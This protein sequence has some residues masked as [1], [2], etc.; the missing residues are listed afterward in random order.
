[1]FLSAKRYS[2]LRLIAMLIAVVMVFSATV[3]T[4]VP[5]TFVSAKSEEQELKDEIARL[6]KEQKELKK[7]RDQIND[8]LS[9]EK[10]KQESYQKEIDN[11]KEQLEVY[12]EQIDTVNGEISDTEEK[13]E[14]KQDEIKDTNNDITAKEAEI[15]ENDELFK[16]RLDTMYI[17]NSSNSVLAMLLGAESFSDFLSATETVKSISESDQ[18]LLEELDQQH[19]ELQSLKDKL[20]KDKQELED[21]K[22]DLED[23]KAELVTAK[24][25]YEKKK[26]ELDDLY[27]ESGIKIASYKDQKEDIEEEIMDHEVAIK[28]NEADLKKLQEEASKA[29]DEWNNSHGGGSSSGG[30]GSD[31]G[32]GSGSGS[33]GSDGGSSQV[34]P[35]TG[36]MWPLDGGHVTSYY[37]GAR[38]HKGVDLSTGVVGTKIFASRTGKVVDVQY[39]DGHSKDDMQS[40]G[41]MVR[42]YH[43]ETGT[44]TRYA[45]CVS[46]AVSEGQW[47]NQGQVIAYMGNTGNSFGPHLHFELSTGASNS[48][49]INPLPYIQ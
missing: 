20:E 47:V 25:D 10:E 40:Y 42:I 26:D 19:K 22:Q 37:G 2:A 13:I 39:W 3:Y 34:K 48:T 28:E 46:I 38:G 17:A 5:Q 12:Q 49:R 14:T 29:D 44:Y 6:E 8:N 23:Q 36:Y 21:A 32:S 11:V 4:S 27:E 1:M 15:E 24:A 31:G 33:G 30:G 16:E 43:P 41:N 9:A 18:Q 7:K 45:H 35:S